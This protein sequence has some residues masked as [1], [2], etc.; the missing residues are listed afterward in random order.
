MGQFNSIIYFTSSYL[1]YK[2]KVKSSFKGEK[3]SG[4]KKTPMVLADL[5]PALLIPF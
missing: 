3:H 2:F 1:L 4:S 5:G